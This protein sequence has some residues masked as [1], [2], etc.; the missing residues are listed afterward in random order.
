MLEILIA[1]GLRVVWQV[2]PFLLTCAIF[3]AFEIYAH[4]DSITNFSFIG[5]P[6]LVGLACNALV[7]LGNGGRMPV[8][9]YSRSFSLWVKAYDLKK[10]RF[11]KLCDRYPLFKTKDGDPAFVFSIGDVFILGPALLFAGYLSVLLLI[12]MIQWLLL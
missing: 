10:P 9:G 12:D 1:L 3:W 8:I 6:G 5:T 4:L 2:K 11:L 7:T